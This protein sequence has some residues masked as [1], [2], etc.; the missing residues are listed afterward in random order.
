MFGEEALSDWSVVPSPEHTRSEADQQ[1]KTSNGLR[2]FLE[3]GKAHFYNLYQRSVPSP[4]ALRLSPNSD[5]WLLGHR[6]TPSQDRTEQVLAHL[7]VW[8]LLL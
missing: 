7:N 5:F 2:G 4:S 6:Y 8:S 3:S 1:T